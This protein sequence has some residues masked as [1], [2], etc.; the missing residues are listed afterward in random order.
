M[1]AETLQ[2]VQ[3]ER[4]ETPRGKNTRPDLLFIDDNALVRE[5][6]KTLLQQKYHEVLT[7]DDVFTGL[8]LLAVH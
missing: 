3:A 1:I 2:Q 8:C 6:V 5:T 4:K 7:T